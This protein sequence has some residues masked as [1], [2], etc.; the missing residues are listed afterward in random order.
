MAER[1]ERPEVGKSRAHR[2]YLDEMKLHHHERTKTR[3]TPNWKPKKRI[4]MSADEKRYHEEWI[5]RQ[6]L[7][8]D[9]A[10]E[11]IQAN[12]AAQAEEKARQKQEQ[13]EQ[14]RQEKAQQDALAEA[15]K[16]AEKAAKDQNDRDN[17]I[18]DSLLKED[19]Q[20]RKQRNQ[21]ISNG[22][23]ALGSLAPKKQS[24]SVGGLDVSYGMLFLFLLFFLWMT[25]SVAPGHQSSRLTVIWKA[26]TGQENI[27]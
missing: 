17:K 11:Q 3:K 9:E 5:N 4:T 20:N 25:I 13:Q 22:T 16:A 26:I 8:I 23:E 6:R 21:T 24:L 19:A 10:A 7:M 27:K 2:A 12:S 14:A 18:R 15:N 1:K